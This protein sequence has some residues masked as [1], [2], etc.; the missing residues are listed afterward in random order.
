MRYNS[1]LYFS[2]DKR[3]LVCSPYSIENLHLMASD[4]GIKRCWY[5]S[6][7]YPHYDIPKKKIEE[8]K[9][10]TKV[11]SPREIIKIIKSSIMI[12]ANEVKKE[13]FKSKAMAKFSHYCAG[14]LYYEV[15]VKGDKY[16]FPISTIQPL[17]QFEG[18]E[19]VS[20]TEF[21]MKTEQVGIALSSD[22]GTTNF[23]AEIKGS[24]LNRWIGKAIEKGEFVY[25]GKA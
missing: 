10:K 20:D 25:I 17:L 21:E 13:L 1:L 5:H 2:D 14:N 24:D 23:S 15:E 19:K 18:L 22:L 11:V 4:L 6:K 9:T 3:H 7:P 16:Q 12:E 8:I